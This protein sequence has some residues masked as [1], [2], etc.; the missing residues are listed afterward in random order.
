MYKQIANRNPP[1]PQDTPP[2]LRASRNNQERIH[3]DRTRCPHL[4]S[5]PRRLRHFWGSSHYSFVDLLI[6]APLQESDHTQ[7]ARRASLAF[8]EYYLVLRS[9]GYQYR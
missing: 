5:S 1:S 8:F 2:T 3:L 6:S 4:A 7:R 9:V